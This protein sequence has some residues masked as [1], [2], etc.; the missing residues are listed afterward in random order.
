MHISVSIK[1]HVDRVPRFTSR[2]ATGQCRL[3]MQDRRAGPL[4]AS[5]YRCAESAPKITVS[6]P[7]SI[8]P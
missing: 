3:N 5:D 7:T 1:N 4:L 2:A 6:S 8:S